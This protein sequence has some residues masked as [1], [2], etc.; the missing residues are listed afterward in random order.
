MST[1]KNQ[2]LRFAK[3]VTDVEKQQVYEGS[4]AEIFLNR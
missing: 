1:I 4:V 2:Q 3:Q